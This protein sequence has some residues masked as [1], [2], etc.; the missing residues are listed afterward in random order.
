MI[1]CGILRQKQL[2]LRDIF[3]IGKPIN[4]YIKLG[5]VQAGGGGGEGMVTSDV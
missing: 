1:L 3:K 2:Y 4:I 5:T